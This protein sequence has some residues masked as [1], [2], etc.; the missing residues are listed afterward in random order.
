M[1]LVVILLSSKLVVQFYNVWSVNG[2]QNERFIERFNHFG[3]ANFNSIRQSDVA[4]QLIYNVF[5]FLFCLFYYLIWEKKPN[6]FP[7]SRVY[8]FVIQCQ[9]QLHF[10][11]NKT[12]HKNVGTCVNAFYLLSCEAF[13]NE[14]YVIFFSPKPTYGKVGSYYNRHAVIPNWQIIVWI[15]V[16]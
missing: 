14:L 12:V 11:F 13:V 3:T 10:R 9:L 15:S 2:V 8:Q 7:S 16:L 4:S 1:V 5:W 6:R